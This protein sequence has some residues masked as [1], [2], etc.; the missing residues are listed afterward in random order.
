MLCLL[1]IEAAFKFFDK[2][3]DGFISVEELGEAMKK[4]GLEMSEEE[5]KDMIKAV[6]R[7]GNISGRGVPTQKR[8]GWSSYLS[9]AC[10]R[11]GRCLKMM[12]DTFSS[13]VSSWE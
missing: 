4:L 11:S 8:P 13:M 1:E 3:G 10:Y 7:N 6:D 9:G 2:N 5:L 12:S